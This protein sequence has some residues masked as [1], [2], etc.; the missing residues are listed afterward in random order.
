MG[1]TCSITTRLRVTNVPI[2]KSSAG[3]ARKNVALIKNL[4]PL[5]G[6]KTTSLRFHGENRKEL[7]GVGSDQVCDGR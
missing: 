7:G 3:K 1:A 5:I 4:W 6:K 2:I